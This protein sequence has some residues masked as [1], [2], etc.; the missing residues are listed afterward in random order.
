MN[1]VCEQSEQLLNSIFE[2]A[3][4]D[5]R[6]SASQTDLGCTLS[7]EGPDSSL[8]LNQGGELLDA[9]QQILNQ[10]YGRDLPKGQRIVCD[11]NNYRAARESELRAMADHAA[12]Q[13]RNTSSPFVFGPMDASERRI[14]HLALAEDADLVTESI[15]EGHARRLRVALK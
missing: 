8:L 13:V 15:G 12:R 2:G 1:D 11:A 14:I 6:A 5:V 3:R 7:I 10:A 9:L 4:F